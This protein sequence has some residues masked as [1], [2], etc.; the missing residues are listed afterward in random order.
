MKSAG[1]FTRRQFIKV[2]SVT[3]GVAL[4]G[5]SFTKLSYAVAKDYI[6][7]RLGSV[8]RQD[9]SM[10]YRKSQ[11]NPMVKQIYKEF[12]EHPVS[13]KSHHLLH[14]EYEDR[15][16]AYKDLKKKGIKLSV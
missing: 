5:L 10:K 7:A 15:S 4:I 8:Y 14:T 12:L 11:D 9:A 1:N 2:S 13:H 16:G 3:A 6:S